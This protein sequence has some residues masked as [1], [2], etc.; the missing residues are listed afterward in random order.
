LRQGQFFPIG[1]HVLCHS[2]AIRVVHARQVWKKKAPANIDVTAI[3]FNTRQPPRTL[4]ELGPPIP[5][6]SLEL[7]PGASQA[8]PDGGLRVFPKCHRKNLDG[9]RKHAAGYFRVK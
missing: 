2:L 9:M 1:A 3:A 5:V 4:A 7:R 6:E 8:R